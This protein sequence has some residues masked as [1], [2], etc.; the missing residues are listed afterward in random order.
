MSAWLGPRSAHVGLSRLSRARFPL[1]SVSVG[2]GLGSVSV[3]SLP[4][5]SPSSFS[6][7]SWLHS[8]GVGSSLVSSR[9]FASSID[10]WH[11]IHRGS[12]GSH[13]NHGQPWDSRGN[14]AS[15]ALHETDALSVSKL[16]SSVEFALADAERSQALLRAL[17]PKGRALLG[18]ITRADDLLRDSNINDTDA[19]TNTST[20]S[21]ENVC[22]HS[23]TRAD[24]IFH[25]I[26]ENGDGVVS[27]EEFRAFV[28]RH[29][30]RERHEAGD[31][32]KASKLV[33]LVLV[34][35]AIPY[36]GFGFMDNFIM[37]V[38]GDLIDHSLSTHLGLS[39]LA[40]AGLGNLLSDVVGVAAASSI[41]KR[42]NDLGF[43]EPAMSDARAS[44]SDIS[45]A[46]VAG[47]MIGVSIGC[48]V[49][50][51]PLGLGILPE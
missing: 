41:E 22:E 30:I 51:F 2:S 23:H 15:R 26:D 33:T 14:A 4:S 28:E 8:V 25:S 6:S 1:R 49:G 24:Q 3:V 50:M 11:G 19:N 36:V 31:S 44:L 9:S 5:S 18:E 40:A 13:A 10:K 12:H 48:V 17:S 32:M 45:Y 46:R 39:T 34:S 16:A 42:A 37:I 29:K 7:F 27:K 38:A 47:A 20:D 43:Q 21:E 35:T